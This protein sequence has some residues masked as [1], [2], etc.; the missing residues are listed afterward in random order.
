MGKNRFN[1][2]VRPHLTVTPIGTQGVVF[3]RVDL[4]TFHSLEMHSQRRI[5]LT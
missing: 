3:D 4:D 5:H 1:S 2:D